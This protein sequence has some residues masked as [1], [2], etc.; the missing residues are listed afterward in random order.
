MSVSGT[1]NSKVFARTTAST[2]ISSVRV[3]T[4]ESVSSILDMIGSPTR[5]SGT[6]WKPSARLHAQI[7]TIVVKAASSQ[8]LSAWCSHLRDERTESPSSIPATGQT[9][10]M[11]AGGTRPVLVARFAIEVLRRDAGLDDMFVET[12]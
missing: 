12:W 4:T 11:E 2:Y 9:I 8:S 3:V 5:S 10:A 7:A 6:S 1:R